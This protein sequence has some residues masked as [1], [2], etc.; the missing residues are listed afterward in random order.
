MKITLRRAAKIRNRVSAKLQEINDRQLTRL[1][2]EVNIYDPDVINQLHDEADHFNEAFAR[3]M[4]LSVA[5]M[6]I[7][8][9]IGQINAA[10]GVDALLTEQAALL[11]QR[12]VVLRIVSHANI[13]PTVEQITARQTGQVDINKSGGARAFGNIATMS[14]PFLTEE[15]ISG[16]H[17]ILQNIQVRLDDIQER[18]ETIN[19]SKYIELSTETVVTLTMAGLA[20]LNRESV[21]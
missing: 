20:D 16:A 14:I 15:M 19:S 21:G 8:K 12:A 10:E 11:G 1:D 9:S 13:R 17:T 5:L 18:L 2:K 6:E 4:A 3:Y 7:R